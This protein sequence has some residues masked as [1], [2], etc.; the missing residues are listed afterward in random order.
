MIEQDPTGQN[1]LIIAIEQYS[2]HDRTNKILN[3]VFET[4]SSTNICLLFLFMIPQNK[5]HLLSYTDGFYFV[6]LTCL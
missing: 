6:V 2:N 3:V 5:S 1:I 4:I